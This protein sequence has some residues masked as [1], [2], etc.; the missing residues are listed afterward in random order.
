MEERSKVKSG[1]VDACGVIL[2]A[3]AAILVRAAALKIISESSTQELSTLLQIDFGRNTFVQ[4]FKVLKLMRAELESSE[5]LPSLD[6][7]CICRGDC[8]DVVCD[9]LASAP[10]QEEVALIGFAAVVMIRRIAINRISSSREIGRINF[11][12]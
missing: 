3:S 10:F 2:G 9:K 5:Q 4:I 7:I 8:N 12:H 1:D 11:N 6:V